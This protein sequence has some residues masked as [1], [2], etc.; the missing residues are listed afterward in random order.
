MKPEYKNQFLSG[1]PVSTSVMD[2]NG[3][4]TSTTKENIAHVVGSRFAAEMR[5]LF[6]EGQTIAVYV[7][8]DGGDV[9]EG[10]AIV[11]AIRDTDANTHVVGRA[12]SMGAYAALFGKHRTANQFAR[13]S[14]HGASS[15]NPS[16]KSLIDT[17][18]EQL[19]EV[20]TA[21]TRLSE[22]EIKNI[23]SLRGHKVRTFTAKEALEKGIIDQVIPNELTAR[24]DLSEIG[25]EELYKAYASLNNVEQKR[26]VKMEQVLSYLNLNA[27]ASETSALEA[28]RTIKTDGE[29]L[30]A[31]LEKSQAD[32]KVATD[33]VTALEQ[34]KAEADKAL[35][36]SLVEEAVASG[37]ISEE[38][39]DSWVAKATEDYEGVKDL[40]DTIVGQKANASAKELL[41]AKKKK[42]G[43]KPKVEGEFTPDEA[44]VIVAEKGN[45]EDYSDEEQD[46]I[47]AAYTTYNKALLNSKKD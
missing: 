26:V 28:I 21:R 12:V 33:K 2:L 31:E 4:I 19:K 46:K 8:S 5:F 25:S 11:Q 16:A 24:L 29:G 37:K 45:V 22:D 3:I 32:L 43:D 34:D 36:L 38:K 41:E 40:L 15:K 35:A 18:N 30:K 14:L 6:A 27:D 7:N 23:L 10:W 42:D 9:D 39:K 47:F 17:I 13:I 44:F 1:L 20:L